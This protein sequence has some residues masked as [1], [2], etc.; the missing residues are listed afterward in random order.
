MPLE[1]PQGWSISQKLGKIKEEAHFSSFLKCALFADEP[2]NRQMKYLK[3]L[4]EA[5]KGNESL[6]YTKLS[7]NKA[8]FLLSVPM[9]I[10]MLFESLFAL[11]DAFFVAKYVGINGMATVGLTESVLT[12]IY[13]LAWGIS[14]AATAIIARKIGEQKPEDASK[15][16]M[17]IINISLVFGFIIAGFGF[18]F[19]EDI[20][21][22]M[23]GSEALISEGVIYTKIQFLS[24]PIIILLFAL[25][26]A[27]RGS[28]NA[29]KAMRAMIVAN[30]INMGL[31][32]IFIPILHFGVEGAAIATL[33]GRSVGVGIQLHAFFSDK[34]NLKLVFKKWFFD[35]QLIFEILKISAGA[36]GQFI[37]QSASWVF[38]IRILA[39]FGSEVVAGYTIAIRIIVFTILPSW[40]LAN[41]AST[42]VGQN[43]GAGQPNRAATSAWRAGFFNMAFLG[44]VAILFFIFS[45]P[46]VELFNQNEVVVA[47]GVECLKILCAGYIFFGFGMVMSQAINGTGDTFTPSVINIICFW[48]M[49]IPLAYYLAEVL[50]FKQTGVFWAIVISESMLALLA[51]L[52]FKT[53]RWKNNTLNF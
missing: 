45:Q 47:T 27:L 3:L 6:D 31:D 23:G 12:I 26:G 7:I 22:L 33:V 35:Y 44:F 25:G 20:L 39:N 19:S 41:S 10:E 28:G 51:I 34:Y 1:T 53:G 43:L 11:V 46:L 9:V 49:E 29:S 38:L 4:L 8:L 17:Q 37:I 42:L 13:S 52:Y 5:L 40:G 48:L 36:A 16:L 2:P 21:R 15:S 18:V 14:T 30:V 24:S 32:S 50:D